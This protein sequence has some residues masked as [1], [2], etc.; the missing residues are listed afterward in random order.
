MKTI[1]FDL[2]DTLYFRRDAFFIAFDDF[3]N[4][5]HADSK[6]Y[7]NDRCRIRGDEVFYD[8]QKG[9]I[10]S[11][12]MYRYRF[13]TG[14][15]DAGIEISSEQ[16]MQFYYLYKKALYE[17]K[18][19][20]PVISM[21]DFAKSNFEALGI[22]TNGE[23]SHQRNKIKNLGLE[24]W[25]ESELIVISGEHGCPKPDRRLFEISAKKAGKKPEDLIIVGD[26]F[27]N[28]IIPAH[29]LG[30]HTVWID[31]YNENLPPPEYSAKNIKEILEILKKY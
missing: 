30:W 28:D 23:S 15:S 24:E 25:I 12:E 18:L 2:D 14:L 29:E 10:S 4:G 31:L 13:K 11:E 16:A 20:P 22:I 8:A 3:F 6:L 17:M 9:T 26:S 21:L 27:N 5:K 1:F 19:N 7:A